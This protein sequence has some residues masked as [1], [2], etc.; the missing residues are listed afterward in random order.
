VSDPLCVFCRQHPV[1]PRWRPFCSERC[2]LLDL[3][4]WVN[5]DYRIPVEPIKEPVDDDESNER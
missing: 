3:A 2:K 1:D 4:R 5:G